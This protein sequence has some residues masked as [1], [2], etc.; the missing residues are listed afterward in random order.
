MSSVQEQVHGTA[1]AVDGRAALIIGETGSGKSGL[2]FEM[3]A[4]GAELVSDDQ[5]LVSATEG[6]LTVSPPPT[7]AGL[8]EARSIGIV[9]MPYVP[10]A[11]LVLL[12]DLDQLGTE[13]LPPLRERLL[14]GRSVPV[15]FGQRVQ[16]L[17]AILMVLLRQGRL[18]DPSEIGPV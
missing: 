2:A 4:F 8:I 18:L 11:E 17:A 5:V 12:V 15:I 16:G 10:S 3:L 7:I 14:L 9:R 6:G 1:V 13:R